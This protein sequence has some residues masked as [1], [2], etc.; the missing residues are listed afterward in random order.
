MQ[1]DSLPTKHLPKEW[2]NA[3]PIT[4]RTAQTTTSLKNSPFGNW[5]VGVTLGKEDTTEAVQIWEKLK[6]GIQSHGVFLTMTKLESNRPPCLVIYYKNDNSCIEIVD[7][8]TESATVGCLSKAANIWEYKVALV[9]TNYDPWEE[10]EKYY[11]F[12]TKDMLKD[13]PNYRGLILF[14]YFYL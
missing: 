6:D 9:D 1:M 4:F 5:V 13:L 7:G 3:N 2:K 12:L 14:V 10:P 11:T 8:H